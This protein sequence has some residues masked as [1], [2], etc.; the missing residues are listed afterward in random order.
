M[1]RN[2]AITDDISRQRIPQHLLTLYLDQQAQSCKLSEV[3]RSTG[4]SSVQDGSVWWP[5]WM[6]PL[7]LVIGIDNRRVDGD[8][9]VHGIY[10]AVQAGLVDGG[11]R[12]GHLQTANDYGSRWTDFR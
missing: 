4:G 3:K 5:Q 9:G 1:S 10:V 12:A 11:D 6:P 7:V 2:I 8:K